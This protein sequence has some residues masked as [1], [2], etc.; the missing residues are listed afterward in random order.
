MG[1]KAWFGAIM[2]LR[3]A[4]VT[5]ITGLHISNRSKNM[6]ANTFSIVSSSMPF[7]NK[8]TSAVNGLALL[9]VTVM[10]YSEALYATPRDSTRGVSPGDRPCIPFLWTGIVNQ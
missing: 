7:I 8:R 10:T 5:L 4:F 1:R 9:C 6:N 2:V 3:K